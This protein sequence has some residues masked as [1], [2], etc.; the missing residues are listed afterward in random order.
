[1]NSLQLKYDE[2]ESDWK[3][4][5]KIGGISVGLQL[6]CVIFIFVIAIIL[7]EALA[8]G[9]VEETFDIL[10]QNRLVG[11]I[12]L[13]FNSL[14][15]ICLMLPVFLGVYAVLKK[16]DP[17]LALFLL[18][19]IIIGVIQGITNHGGLS[20]I[21]LSDKYASAVTD[22]EKERFLA[23]GEAIVASNEWH[24][25]SWFMAG[26][27]LQ[28]GAL[29]F[30]ILMLK[31]KQ[32]HRITGIFGILANGLDLIQHLLTLFLP[33]TSY[34]IISVAGIFYLGWYLYLGW[35]LIKYSKENE[36]Q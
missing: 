4:L 28:G 32:F 25:T 34:I 13:D 26:I 11:L 35:D 10:E 33:T 1:M 3:I 8:I 9:T 27:L 17:A 29:L 5:C 14:I 7:N 22:L 15:I 36:K 12:Q 6:C 2:V 19:I 21:D 30:S 20:L 24:S 31:R 18:I 23:A 16:K